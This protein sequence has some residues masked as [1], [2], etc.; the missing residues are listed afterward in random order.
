[1]KLPKAPP[2]TLNVECYFATK[3]TDKMPHR[4]FLTLPIL[5][6]FRANIRVVEIVNQVMRQLERQLA[7]M[8]PEPF[9]N[10]TAGNVPRLDFCFASERQLQEMLQAVGKFQAVRRYLR[11]ERSVVHAAAR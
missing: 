3:L 4:L 9:L 11:N 6:F 1:M 5:G 8:G 10:C 7:I 2:R